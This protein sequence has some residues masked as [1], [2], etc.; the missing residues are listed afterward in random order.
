MRVHAL[1]DFN[2]IGIK[3]RSHFNLA[4]EK[5]RPFLIANPQRITKAARDREQGR[6]TLMFE[7]RIGCDGRADPQFSGW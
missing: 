2:H 4:H 3:R 1:H 6:R 5:F 7:Q